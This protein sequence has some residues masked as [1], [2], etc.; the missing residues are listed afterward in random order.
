MYTNIHNKS[1]V[2]GTINGMSIETINGMSIETINGMSI[3]TINGMSVIYT[4]PK[5]NLEKVSF[6]GFASP[7]NIT[8]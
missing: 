2:L 5:Q 3:E 8:I 1:A 7:V 4:E 6:E